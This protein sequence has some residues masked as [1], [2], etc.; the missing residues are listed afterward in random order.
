MLGQKPQPV[1]VNW[2]MNTLRIN[3]VLEGFGSAA[4]SGACA[5]IALIVT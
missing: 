5:F 3:D 2:L 4:T 1:P